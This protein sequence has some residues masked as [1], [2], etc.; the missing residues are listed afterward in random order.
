MPWFSRAFGVFPL[1]K[2]VVLVMMVV[3]LPSPVVEIAIIASA[4]LLPIN[5]QNIGLNWFIYET[6]STRISLLITRCVNA[7]TDTA[8]IPVVRYG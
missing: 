6:N 8:L 4:R 7:P 1:F 2:F 3:S 5:K